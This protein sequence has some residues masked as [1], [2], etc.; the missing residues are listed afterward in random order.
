MIFRK[1]DGNCHKENYYVKLGNSIC[2]A[3]KFHIVSFFFFYLGSGHPTYKDF[4]QTASPYLIIQYY[5]C[6]RLR[7]SWCTN[8]GS[9]ADDGAET[10]FTLF[11]DQ[12]ILDFFFVCLMKYFAAL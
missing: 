10:L 8:M 3:K 11:R 6:I 2:P 12:V 7:N 4:A 1:C 9:P 5:A